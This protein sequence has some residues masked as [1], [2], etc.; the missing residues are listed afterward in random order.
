MVRR[1]IRIV[2]EAF[3]LDGTF[4]CPPKDFSTLAL[5]Y[6]PALFEEAGVEPPTADW[7]WEDL[8]AAATQISE[9]TEANGLVLSPDFARYIAFLY[10]A[11]GSV[12]NE[13][14]TEITINSPE[15]LEALNLYVNLVLDG[16]AATPSA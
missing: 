11:G 12:A 8:E 2:R 6:N 9:N 4:W 1:S 13:D 5:I 14:F 10:Q 7:T 3:T 16:A 15:A